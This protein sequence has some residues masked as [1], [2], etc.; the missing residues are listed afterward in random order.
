MLCVKGVFST[1]KKHEKVEKIKGLKNILN[2]HRLLSTPTLSQNFMIG[3][4]EQ[5]GE[6]GRQR[7]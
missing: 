1:T 4:R 3:H 5:N 6:I 7:C 2:L